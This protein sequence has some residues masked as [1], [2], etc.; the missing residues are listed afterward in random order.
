MIFLPPT[1]P[2]AP[3]GGTFQGNL[4]AHR[5][6]GAYR[7]YLSRNSYRPQSRWRPQA[8]PFKIF[9]PPTEPFAPTGGTFQGNLTAH[10]AVGAYR[11]YLS[12]NS[13]RPQ[14]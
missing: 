14:S 1:E 12:R 7:R 11:R 10:R 6:V 9:L 4:T 3:T 5:A 8:V 2:F 13:Y